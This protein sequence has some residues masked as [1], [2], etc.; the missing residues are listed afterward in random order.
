MFN[1]LH[2]ERDVAATSFTSHL[3]TDVCRRFI[4]MSTEFN[5]L[6]TSAHEDSDSSSS[7]NTKDENKATMYAERS[8]TCL[9]IA[10]QLNTT[11]F[12]KN[13]TEVCTVLFFDK[14][15]FEKLDANPNL[16]GVPNGVFDLEK[17][18]FRE[19]RPDDYISFTTAT[20][21]IPYEPENPKFKE[22]L[23]V[24]TKFFQDILPSAPVRNYV[25]RTIASCFDGNCLD[26]KFPIFTGSGGNGKSI[27]FEFLEHV[28]GN[29]TEKVA[30][31]VFTSKSSGPDAATAGLANIK[32]KRFISCEETEEGSTLNIAKVKEFTGGNKI[33]TR[34][35]YKEK[36]EFKPQAHWF[37]VCNNKPKLP[38]SA[39]QDGG[40]W[41]RI[42]VVNFPA[43]FVDN[44]DDPE[45]D[46]AR[47]YVYKKD[48]KI[49]EKLENASEIWMSYMLNVVYPEYKKTGLQ[50]PEEIRFSTMNYRASN[51]VFQQYI[52]ERIEAHPDGHLK[53]SELWADFKDWHKDA[54]VSS[55]RP[56]QRV[57]KDY[58]EKRLKS[59]YGTSRAK[60]AG[61]RGYRLLPKE[62]RLNDGYDDM[63]AITDK[64]CLIEKDL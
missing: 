61:W 24:I 32:G 29:Y 6:S 51:D 27:L 18:E 14:H 57:F 41:R 38:T 59:R 35:L 54:G 22:G 48:H 36:I 1:G 60:D 56:E 52:T 43:K 23:Q 16:L 64:P 28:M 15:F 25:Y 5:K 19:G 12:Y 9:K 13:I 8:K 37:L 4:E 49:K 17:G 47:P 2:W 21:Y 50:E 7:D 53:F 55:E 44:V 62:N 58:F 11:S 26:Q 42:T 10:T 3:I 46:D 39:C 31:T 40:T 63:P 30:T 34:A 20:R 33:I 45:Y